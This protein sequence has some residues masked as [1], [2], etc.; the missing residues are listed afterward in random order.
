L[1]GG[2]VLVFFLPN[3]LDHQNVYGYGGRLMVAIKK[4][5]EMRGVLA[6]VPVFGYPSYLM[7]RSIGDREVLVPRKD[8]IMMPSPAEPGDMRWL[9]TIRPFPSSIKMTTL[10][11]E[12]LLGRSEWH[13]RSVFYSLVQDSHSDTERSPMPVG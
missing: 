8:I 13:L 6:T 3:A 1:L 7:I 12:M 2:A 10:Q 4:S 9:P 11:I 5:E